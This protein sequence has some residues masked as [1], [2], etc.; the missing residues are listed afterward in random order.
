MSDDTR[1][2]RILRKRPDI[3]RTENDCLVVIHTNQPTL[4]GKRFG[5]EAGRVGVGRGPDSEILLHDDSVSPEG[6]HLLSALVQYVPRNATGGWEERRGELLENCMA[7]LEQY[8]PGIG[9]KVIASEL[10]TP[11]DLERQ[12]RVT[13]G[14]TVVD[15]EPN[16]LADCEHR[17]RRYAKRN[18]RPG[19]MAAVRP[20]EPAKAPQKTDIAPR[21]RA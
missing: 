11:E 1:K 21:R 2:T 14:K 9:G 10:L 20:Q 18:E 7:T 17:D 19:H 8:A 6:S 4:L 3:V 13:G 5:L 15:E 12:F 16:A